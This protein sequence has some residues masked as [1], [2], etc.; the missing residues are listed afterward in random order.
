MFLDSTLLK[1]YMD[2]FIGYGDYRARY[3][4]VG[5][6]EGGGGSLDEVS[7]RLTKWDAAG[8]PELLDLRGHHHEGDL[9]DFVSGSGN[10]Q[11]T[12]SQL[13]RIVLAAED[14][15]TDNDAVRAYQQHRLG[16]AGGETCLLELMPLPSPDAGTWNYRQWSLSS[17]LQSRAVYMKRRAHARAATLQ[18]RIMEYRPPAVVFYSLSYLPWWRLVASVNLSEV[19]ILG[20]K[21]FL[22]H[23][24]HTVFVV[25]PQPAHRAK[26][27]G[28]DYYVRIGREIA[29]ALR[30]MGPTDGTC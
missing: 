20:V 3:W 23:N 14:S 13:I 26:G 19:S 7:R 28:S 10:L 21:S 11:T 2:T 5:M 1:P 22:G 30:T 8:R 29:A 17:D 12:W 18:R 16:R 9:T 25:V 27:K 24:G 4:F 6:E 15:P